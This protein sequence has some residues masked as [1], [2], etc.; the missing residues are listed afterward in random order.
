MAEA[1]LA[2]S[3]L[4]GIWI[5]R[6]IYL[7]VGTRMHIGIS[8]KRERKARRVAA[9]ACLIAVALLYA[10]FASAA[11]QASRANCCTSGHCTIPS[12]HHKSIP[13]RDEIPMDCGHD[14]SQMSDCKMSCCKTT[15]QIAVGAHLFV[16]SDLKIS[17]ELGAKST[18]VAH[19]KVSRISQYEK[20][21]SPPPRFPILAA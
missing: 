19:R 5:W 12:H 3:E 21:Q 1:E 8:P 6:I 7:R 9:W 4:A 10:P 20:P 11:W 17:A 13:G 14:I 16:M 18:E 2:D 15:E